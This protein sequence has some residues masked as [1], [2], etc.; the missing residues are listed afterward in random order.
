MAGGSENISAAI[1]LGEAWR[2]MAYGAAKYG[3]N[4]RIS[5]EEMANGVC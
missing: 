1:A 5:V 3:G 4:Q 2:G